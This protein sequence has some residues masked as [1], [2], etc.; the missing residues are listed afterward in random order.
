MAV[1]E[2]CSNLKTF[3]LLILLFIVCV[4]LISPIMVEYLVDKILKDMG[5]DNSM[6]KQKT[7]VSFIETVS[8]MLVTT[9]IIPILIDITALMEDFQTKSHRQ[10]GIFYRNFFFMMLNMLLLPVTQQ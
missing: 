5:F 1:D 10:L 9:V 7:I 6:L 4:F 8:V 3:L 2:D